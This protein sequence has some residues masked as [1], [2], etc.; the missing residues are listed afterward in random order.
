MPYLAM[1]DRLRAFLKLDAAVL[2][3]SGY[4]FR[5][6][7][8]DDVLLQGVR[9]NPTAAIFALQYGPLVDYPAGIKLA[10][11]APN[12]IVLAEDAGII[13]GV[14]APWRA[15]KQT[16]SIRQDVG[17]LWEPEAGREEDD[18]V[19]GRFL[20][21]DFNKLGNLLAQLVARKVS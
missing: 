9:T 4:S 11:T 18:L 1:V 5:D 21:G 15:L 7:H 14:Q 3:V 13:G 2:T 19:P 17:F 6:E 8:I 10:T 16:A 20:L 12:F